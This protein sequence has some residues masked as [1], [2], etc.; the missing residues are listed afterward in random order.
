MKTLFFLSV[1][2]FNVFALQLKLTEKAS[3]FRQITDIQ[4][5]P[6]TNKYL[7]LEK[8]GKA[9]IWDSQAGQIQDAFQKE[10]QSPSEMGLL[11]AA[12]HPEFSKNGKLLIHYNPK[13]GDKRT[14]IAEI[15]LDR[16]TLKEVNPSRERKLLE[17]VQP[18]SNH[19][20]GQILFGPD[21]YLYIGLGDGGSAGDP[22][23]NS[24]S[25]KSILG[26]ILRINVNKAEDGREYSIPADN[27]FAKKANARPEIFAKG[28]RNPWRFT[29]DA[30]KNLIVADVG[31]NAWEEVSIVENGM[32]YGWN[33]KEGSHCFAQTPCDNPEFLNPWLEY[34]RDAGQ[35]IT[36]GVVYTGTK[37]P[38]LKNK[39]IFGDFASGKIWAVDLPTPATKH[40]ALKTFEDLGTPFASISCFANTA[41]G[42]VLV[43]DFSGGKILQISK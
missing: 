19:K 32:N 25:E 29:W 28:L 30:N 2:T 23:G 43:A 8:T 22:Q 42:E 14:R 13:D 27:K 17:Q 33:P 21:G 20:G 38:E 40:A 9:K 35:S 41:D 4:R 36:G 18:F 11:G 1:L 7:V 24:Q 12:F 31:Q 39:Y 26:K 16:T 6:G 34:D 5:V 37:V 3:G 10:V 15:V